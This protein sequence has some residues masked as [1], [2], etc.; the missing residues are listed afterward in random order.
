LLA[1]GKK[2][3]PFDAIGLRGEAFTPAAYAGR[4]VLI[5][6]WAT[7]CGPC[8]AE[9]P[10][11]KKVYEEFHDRGFEILGVSL[12]SDRSELLSFLAENEMPWPQFFDGGGWSNRIA[13]LYGTQSIPSAY[14]LDRDG[15]IRA[16]GSDLRGEQLRRQVARLLGDGVQ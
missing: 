11:I 8:R 9:L 6:F 14:L 12:D 5:D 15:V 7:W 13:K 2:T 4:V 3:I 16:F 1:L 10:G